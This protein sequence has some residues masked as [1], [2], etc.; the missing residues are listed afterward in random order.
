VRYTSEHKNE[1]RHRILDAAAKLF[2]LEGIASVSVADVMADAG[3]T[4]GGFYRYFGSKEDLV[5]EAMTSA[6]TATH[7]YLAGVRDSD[8]GGL[9]GVLRAY[10]RDVRRDTPADGCI[11]SLLTGELAR[12]PVDARGPFVDALGKFTKLI[13]DELPSTLPLADR[14]RRARTIF[15]LMVGVMQLARLTAPLRSSDAILEDGI[16][17][18]L[19]LAGCVAR[20][21]RSSTAPAR[22]TRPIARPRGTGRA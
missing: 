11:F 19:E 21:A 7:K 16:Q 14:R 17:A 15:A 8:N 4:H 12:R 9:E 5:A 22:R 2:R 1:T 18:A 13:A 3:L 20:S 6:A 10:L